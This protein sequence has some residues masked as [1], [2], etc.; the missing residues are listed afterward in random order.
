MSPK[1]RQRTALLLIAVMALLPLHAIQAAWGSLGG[2]V[3]HGAGHTAGHAMQQMHGM[4]GCPMHQPSAQQGHA[5]GHCSGCD[6]CGT[7]TA[8]LLP[9]LQLQP[10]PTSNHPILTA[11]ATWHPAPPAYPLFRPPR[12]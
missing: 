10:T 3:A 1:F 4:Q 12:A 2:H 8:A 11:V 6:L 7:C 9:T 5:M